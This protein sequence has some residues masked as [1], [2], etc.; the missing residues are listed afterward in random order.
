MRSNKK[1][2]LANRASAELAHQLIHD[3]SNLLHALQ[4]QL[5]VSEVQADKR[6][7]EWN[8]VKTDCEKLARH[9]REWRDRWCPASAAAEKSDVNKWISEVVAELD[10]TGRRIRFVPETRSLPVLTMPELR[11][12]LYVVMRQMLA[13]TTEESLLVQ[14]ERVSDNVLVR[15]ITRANADPFLAGFQDVADGAGDAGTLATAAC[16]SL[17]MRVDATI[18]V[19]HAADN[20]VHFILEIPQRA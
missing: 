12:L 8:H 14:S 13:G 1:L 5:K 16:K 3:C 9:L 18:R 20:A 2:E 11:C 6:M 7:L 17:A 19:T 4:L 15:I 10:P